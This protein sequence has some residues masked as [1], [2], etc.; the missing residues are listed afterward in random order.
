M[1]QHR[2]T[3][4]SVPYL[5][6]EE[7]VGCLNHWIYNFVPCVLLIV[8]SRNH[9]PTTV[10][11]NLVLFYEVYSY[12]YIYILCCTIIILLLTEHVVL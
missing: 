2:G 1:L 8:L 7:L 5:D 4:K 3:H 10:K 9:S 6:G 12:N 11:I